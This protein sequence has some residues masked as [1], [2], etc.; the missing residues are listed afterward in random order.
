MAIQLRAAE[1]QPPLNFDCTD[2]L[3]GHG[4]FNDRRS[5]KIGS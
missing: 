1:R 4:E 3:H 5:E 2:S